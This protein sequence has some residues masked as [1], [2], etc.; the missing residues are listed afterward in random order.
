MPRATRPSSPSRRSGGRCAHARARAQIVARGH[1]ATHLLTARALQNGAGIHGQ[2]TVVGPFY[3]KPPPPKKRKAEKAAPAGKGGGPRGATGEKKAKGAARS[4]GGEGG[5]SRRRSAGSKTGEP[6]PPPEPESESESDGEPFTERF[7]PLPIFGDPEEEAIE[8]VAERCYELA[9]IACFARAFG[10][11]LNL[12]AKAASLAE[13]EKAFCYYPKRRSATIS[14]LHYR[15]LQY[16]LA[17]KPLREVSTRWETLLVQW[18]SGRKL[19]LFGGGPVHTTQGGWFGD[20]SLDYSDLPLRTRAKL[21]LALCEEWATSDALRGVMSAIYAKPSGRPKDWRGSTQAPTTDE[22]D[23][24]M[25]VLGESVDGSVW[26]D[27]SFGDDV[28]VCRQLV[29]PGATD[30]EG[31]LI[32]KSAAERAAERTAAAAVA[33]KARADALKAMQ[34]AARARE[35]REQRA[36]AEQAAA[37]AVAAVAVAPGGAGEALYDVAAPRST[38]VAGDG[39]SNV[40]PHSLAT[41][42]PTQEAS[43]HATEDKPHLPSHAQARAE[44]Q[45]TSDKQRETNSTAGDE[46]ADAPAPICE[47]LRGAGGEDGAPTESDGG[48]VGDGGSYLSAHASAVLSLEWVKVLQMVKADMRLNAGGGIRSGIQSALRCDPPPPEDVAKRLRYAL[49]VYKGN[50]AGPCKRIAMEAL[51]G[52]LVE[53]GCVTTGQGQG[54]YKCGSAERLHE[55]LICGDAKGQSGCGKEC[56]FDCAGLRKIPVGDWYCP[57]CSER[58]LAEASAKEIKGMYAT[59]SCWQTLATTAE[60]ATVL[61]SRLAASKRKRH[62]RLARA[63]EDV[64]RKAAGGGGGGTAGAAGTD[65]GLVLAG[66]RRR[67]HVCYAELDG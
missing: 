36:R 42:G 4:S 3:R 43:V 21:L 35:E 28:R 51:Q 47:S 54:C 49:T 18:A 63:L 10:T 45:G 7:V 48:D 38:T 11:V 66:R 1:A 64:A 50:S 59:D 58:M 52:H 31:V 30:E 9:A 37:A 17:G 33:A 14:E 2:P 55:I 65:N 40:P 24:R 20:A 27:F 39:R 53:N 44:K 46:G 19:P 56:H 13:L 61:A 6:A 62:R 67:A 29:P 34:S 16:D 25:P 60:A 23:P 15:L 22:I 41:T 26:Y 5:S 57:E 32:I 12:P 8:A